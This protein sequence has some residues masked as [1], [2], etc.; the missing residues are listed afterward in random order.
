MT[1]SIYPRCSQL[2]A[3]DISETTYQ[4]L[5][6]RDKQRRAALRKCIADTFVRLA[7]ERAQIRAWQQELNRL[8]ARENARVTHNH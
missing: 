3:A 8:Q 2:R 6:S 4:P 5:S 1:E 7:E